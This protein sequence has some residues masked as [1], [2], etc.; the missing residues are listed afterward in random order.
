MFK[1]QTSAIALLAGAAV[2]AG[3]PALAQQDGTQQE[4][5]RGVVFDDRNGNGARDDG[6]PG[7]Q[8][9]RV[10][11]GT[12][13]VLTD[14]EGRYELPV[15]NETII[16]ITKP[17]GYAVPVNDQML[18]QFYYIHYPDGTPE[19]LGLRYPGI[20]PT[21]PLPES[22]DFAIQQSEEP[23][24]FKVIL[25]SDT[26]PQTAEEIDY[27]RDDVVAE[28]IGTDAAFG[29]T[30][31]DIMFDDL[32]LLP[33]YNSVVA[34]IGV[35]WHNVPGNHELN[36]LSPDDK[37]S[38]ETFK[39]TFGPPYYGFEY[40]DAFFVV[41]D[42]VDY[43][44]RDAGRDEPTYR[45][46]G[47]YEGR[48][49]QEQLQ[50]LANELEH[51]PEDKLVFVTTHIPL[52][53]P[54]DNER[55]S[56][57]T[58]NRAELFAVLEGRGHLYSVAGHTHTTDH[59]YFGPDD[60]FNGP[61]PLHHH[62][63]ATVSGSWWSGPF[64]ERGIPVA[65]QRDGTPNGYHILEVDGNQAT[66]TYKAAG[67]PADHQMRIMF[68]VSYHGYRAEGM[69]DFRTGALLDGRLTVDE[70]PATDIFVNLFDGGPNSTV[71]FRIGDRDWM[72]MENTRTF[73][74]FANELFLRNPDVKKPWVWED[75]EPF[76]SSHIYVAD[77]PADLQ[78]GF[79]TVTV[80]ATDEFGRTHT[81]HAVL[82]IM[83]FG[84]PALAAGTERRDNG[85][86]YAAG[87]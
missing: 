33:R 6:E 87:E 77:L 17:A 68:D 36:F 4:T 81:D 65:L 66:M 47:V 61:E 8:D 12:D 58:L 9:V 69:R 28:L 60:G 74:P 41:L 76:M 37:Y 73:D 31:G 56:V 46:N 42:N 1:L 44:G 11:N 48:I 70:V 38:L 16:F 43:L 63:M 3:A 10:S 26:Q 57:N 67:Q 79:Y 34:R 22:V 50:W 71:E 20:A 82:E 27:I 55:A 14:A 24:R 62:I 40:G 64:D 21:G 13:V 25:F 83:G 59:V 85:V 30:T 23:S 39:R 86:R 35:P 75:G 32:S 84:T 2:L 18:P 78:P 15:D 5:A 53:W 72:P 45:G 49:S 52:E 54:L 51:V 29:I 7:V 19:E 80:R